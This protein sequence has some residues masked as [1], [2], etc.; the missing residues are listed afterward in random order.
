VVFW[1]FLFLFLFFDPELGKEPYLAARRV[2]ILFLNLDAKGGMFHF[3]LE[4]VHLAL[5]RYLSSV[6]GESSLGAVP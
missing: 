6:S 4:Q 5:K 2:I 1:V 3:L